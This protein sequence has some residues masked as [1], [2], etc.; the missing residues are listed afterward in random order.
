[1][2]PP[3][4]LPPANPRQ[5]LIERGKVVAADCHGPTVLTSCMYNNSPIVHGVEVTAFSNSEEAAV[6]LTDKVPFLLES[7]F[8]ENGG[9]YISGADW[10]SHAVEAKVG[11]G[12]LITGQN[13]QSSEAAAKLVIAKFQ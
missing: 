11:P 4:T 13:P 5:L 7:R 8:V 10:G 6:G 2:S 3:L 1:V 12:T 9:K